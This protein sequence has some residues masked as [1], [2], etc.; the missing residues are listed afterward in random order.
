MSAEAKGI[1]SL[2]VKKVHEDTCLELLVAMLLL[3]Q[4]SREAH[5]SRKSTLYFPEL[6]C[7]N[8]MYWSHFTPVIKVLIVCHQNHDQHITVFLVS[9]CWMPTTFK[10]FCFI[11][12]DKNSLILGKQFFKVAK[13]AT[14]E[15]R[16]DSPW[17]HFH[18]VSPITSSQTEHMSQD[19]F[20]NLWL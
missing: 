11:L 16:L 8:L 12:Q 14:M 17:A 20:F 4:R 3:K 13:R 1:L 15:A 5:D 6:Y 10:V 9:I 7:I 19:I 2:P 18:S